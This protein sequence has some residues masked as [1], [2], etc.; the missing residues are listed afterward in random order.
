LR[1]FSDPTLDAYVSEALSN[2]ADLQSAAM[3]LEQARYYVTAAGAALYPAVNAVARGG[4]NDAD[5]NSGWQGAVLSASWEL[6]VWG[7]VRAGRAAATEAYSAAQSDY[8]YARQSLAAMTAKSWFTAS[9]A[10]LQL[11]IADMAV[12]TAE[13]LVDLTRSRRKVGAGN[14]YDIA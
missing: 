9:E 2:N 7:R 8:E 5:P 1:E 3:K 4:K 14:D 13:Q 6:D 12:R 10:L 11:K